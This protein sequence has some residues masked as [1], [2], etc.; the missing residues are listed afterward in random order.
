[1]AKIGKSGNVKVARAALGR[2]RKAKGCTA[3]VGALVEAAAHT[4]AALRGGEKAPGLHKA[5]HAAEKRVVKACRWAGTKTREL[6][7]RLPRR[8]RSRGSHP[9]KVK[10]SREL[11]VEADN[12]RI[13]AAAEKGVREGDFCNGYLWRMN[14]KRKQIVGGLNTCDVEKSLRQAREAG[15]DSPW[16]NLD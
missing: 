11:S 1:M 16:F 7:R 9:V 3:A 2:L 14:G 12:K 13:L 5:L 6:V 15:A 4:G 8:S 10:S